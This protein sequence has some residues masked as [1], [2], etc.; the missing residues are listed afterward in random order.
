MRSYALALRNIAITWSFQDSLD[1]ALKTMMKADS[2]ITKLGDIEGL[3]S[4]KNC[5]GNIYEKKNEYEIAK[6]YYKLSL[7]F[8]EDIGKG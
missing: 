6:S 5:I 3:F 2:I 4:I 1:L 7:S 8:G